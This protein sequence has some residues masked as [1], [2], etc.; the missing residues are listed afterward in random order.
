MR[1]IPYAG[2]PYA[3]RVYA[4]L[5]AAQYDALVVA[6]RAKYQ[7]N[8][9]SLEKQGVI[10]RVPILDVPSYPSEDATIAEA[11]CQILAYFFPNEVSWLKARAA[12]HKQSRFWAGANVQSDIRRAKTWLWPSGPPKSLTAPK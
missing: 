6:W 11:S 2:S 3:A 10:A 7:Y 4:L 8:R 12:E 1:L 9:P 5:S